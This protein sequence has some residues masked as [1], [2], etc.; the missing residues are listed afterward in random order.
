[1]TESNTKTPDKKDNNKPSLGNVIASTLAAAAGIQKDSN[2]ERDFQHGNFKHFVISGIVFTILFIGIVIA[3]VNLVLSDS[4]TQSTAP[5]N[6]TPKI[7]TSNATTNSQI[8]DFAA[9][10]D[11][12][13]KKQAF[14]SFIYQWVVTENKNILKHR[15]SLIYIKKQLQDNKPITA[16]TL[17]DVN[18]IAKRNKLAT[19]NNIDEKTINQLLEK[20]DIIPAALALA[21]SAN[22]S[23][24]GTSRFATKANNYFG[25]WCFS[26][27]CGLVPKKRSAGKTH[28]VAKFKSPQQSVISYMQNLNRNSAYAPLRTIRAQ[29]R[30]QGKPITGIALAK[31]LKRY[32]ERGHAYVEEIQSMIRFNKLGQYD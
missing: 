7:E 26:K 22:E 19:I 13:Q 18:Q 4:K 30:K 32:S 9:I 31:G 24:W 11:V 3:V 29:L 16:R 1:M 23:A 10:T 17:E 20:I 21:Q 5:L 27:G 12:K 15:Q 14:F 2:R 6:E 8:P 28:E 25:Q